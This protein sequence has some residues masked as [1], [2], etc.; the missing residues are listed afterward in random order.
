MPRFVLRF[1]GPG[2][3][4]AE[5][6]QRVASLPDTKVVAESARML[7]VEAPAAL[8]RSLA[9]ALPQWT[10]SPEQFVPVPRVGVKLRET[11]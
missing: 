11:T 8:E 3:K 9:E 6:L 4:P 2:E 10:L 5:D 1:E 7:L